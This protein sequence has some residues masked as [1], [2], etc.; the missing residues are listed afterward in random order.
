MIKNIYKHQY[1]DSGLLGAEI[2]NFIALGYKELNKNEA[3]RIFELG[4]S[5]YPQNYN[6]LFNLAGINIDDNKPKKALSL[7]ENAEKLEKQ[8]VKCNLTDKKF[9]LEDEINYENFSDDKIMEISK[10]LITELQKY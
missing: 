4:L 5:Y 6:M 10:I 8:I 7:L 1:N 3:I 9:I 2:F